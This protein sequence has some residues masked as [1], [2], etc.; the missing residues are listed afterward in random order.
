MSAK[1]I[2]EKNSKGWMAKAISHLE[3]AKTPISENMQYEELTYQ[4]S[5]SVECSI[6][7]LM[8]LNLGG[9]RWGHDLDLL[10]KEL[11]EKEVV[12]PDD[13]KNAAIGKYCL[14]KPMFKD[15]YFTLPWSPS[16][17]TS[18]KENTKYPSDD[19]HPYP[20]ISKDG[21]EQALEKAE[22]VVTWVKQQCVN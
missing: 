2:V 11:E 4:C 3:L 22:K 19:K 21:Y 15:G 9:Y 20:P 12:I 14:G 1:W 10:I 6:K 18:L 16:P 8:I 5:L 7:T 13:I 17:T